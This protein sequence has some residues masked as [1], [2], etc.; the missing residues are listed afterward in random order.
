MRDFKFRVWDGEKFLKNGSF[1]LFPDD[2]GGF[3]VRA[4]AFYGE[5]ADVPNA[6]IQQFTGMKDINDV[7]IY[8][9]DL[10]SLHYA[11]QPENLPEAAG[12][13]EVVFRRASF[14]LKQHKHN[15]FS[16]SFGDP[17]INANLP[18]D[19]PKFLIVDSLPLGDFNICR[20]IGNIFDRPDLKTC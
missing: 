18:E 20:V 9:G 4:L 16:T 14:Y 5:L 13:Y 11:S 2:N 12:I 8:E 1:C 6:V 3:E 19:Q 7:D 10:V 17:K 15:W